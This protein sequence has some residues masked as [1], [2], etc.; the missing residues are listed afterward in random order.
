MRGKT[1][2]KILAGVVMTAHL[3]YVLL[4]LLSIPVVFVFP[5]LSLVMLILPS[6]MFAL[7][8]LFGGCPVTNLEK[9]LMMKYDP[10]KV[11]DGTFI[12]HYLNKFFK[13]KTTNK[14]VVVISYVIVSVLVLSAVKVH[15]TH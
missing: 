5:S 10:Q 7:W 2:Y 9:K 14:Q 6:I 13:I 12:P 15:F 1:K 4:M 3:L 11:Y 8:F